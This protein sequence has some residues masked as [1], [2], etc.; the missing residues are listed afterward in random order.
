MACVLTGRTPT[1]KRWRH[2]LRTLSSLRMCQIWNGSWSSNLKT[3]VF[4]Y[5]K[6]SNP[7][8]RK[9]PGNEAISL[10]L[11][12][13]YNTVT[14]GQCVCVCASQACFPQYSAAQFHC[15]VLITNFVLWAL[16][17][18]EDSDGR[19]TWTL[20][21]SQLWGVDHYAERTVTQ[22]ELRGCFIKPSTDQIV[23]HLRNT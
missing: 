20:V 2:I 8:S 9:R 19:V 12:L 6:Q 11:L 23:C 4:T 13:S 7:G 18:S 5:R 22:R 15:M 3:S 17:R 14:T 21:S 1:C 10:M 16:G